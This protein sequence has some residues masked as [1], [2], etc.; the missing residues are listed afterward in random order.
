MA[1]LQDS[2]FQPGFELSADG[3]W[4]L[5]F[6]EQ[7]IMVNAVK[8]FCMLMP[9]SRTRE[10]QQDLRCAWQGPTAYIGRLN[11]R[12]TLDRVLDLVVHHRCLCG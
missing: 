11:W 7:G 4:C 3:G 9:P 2:C 10:F 8:R 5:R 12:S 1:L 6:G